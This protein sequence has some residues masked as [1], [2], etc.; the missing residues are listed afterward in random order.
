[1]LGGLA[2]YAIGYALLET[3]GQW[4]IHLYGLGDRVAEFQAAYNRWGLW[5]ILIKGLT[6]I[7]FKL[8]TI[9]SGM[10]HFSLPAF[11]SRI[12]GHARCAVLPGCCPASLVRRAC[13]R[14]HRSA[15]DTGDIGL[16]GPG[17]RRLPLVAL[18]LSRASG[19]ETDAPTGQP[20]GG[21]AR[22]R[23][24]PGAAE[25]VRDAIR[26]RAGALPSLYLER[27]PY[28]VA[29][30]RARRSAHG[31]SASGAY[32]GG[33][34][35]GRRRHDRRLPCGR[36]A[37]DVRASRICI[38]GD[39]AQSIDQLRQMLAHAGPRCDQVTAEFLGFSLAFWNLLLSLGL[40]VAALVGFWWTR[41]V[42]S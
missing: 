41:P 10:A 14:L 35:D 17:R 32:G 15:I 6:P 31:R 42:R 26:L 2:G 20:L 1:M 21:C 11:D 38:A 22:C 3:V 28:L 25:R 19:R 40:A 12:P 18:S 4:I 7:P 16:C 8:V 29:A 39:R 9:A 30:A 34:G 13:P 24:D 5:I 23:G 27:W 33:T 37:R 36:R